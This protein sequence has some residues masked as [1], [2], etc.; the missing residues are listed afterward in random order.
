MFEDFSFE[1]PYLLLLFLLFLLLNRYA[2]ADNNAYYIPHFYE[3]LPHV[4]S[5]HYIQIVLKWL[6]VSSA[7]LAFASPVVVTGMKK[8]ES[9]SIDIVLSLDAS[10][11]MSLTGFNVLDDDQSRWDVVKEVVKDF[12]VKR[13]KDRIGLVLFGSTA[14]VASPLSY[15]KEAQLDIVE[16]IELGVV[17]KSTALID[18][19][20]SAISL[21]K[22]SQKSSK[23][24]VLLSDGEDSASKVPLSVAMKFAKK[25]DIKIY[26]VA[27]D[28]GRSNIL[29][30]ISKES[31]GQ[32]FHANNKEDLYEI[33]RTIDTLE[34][35]AIPDKNIKIVKY[36]AF[37]IL[38]LTL[39]A[40][41]LLL[42]IM[43]RRGGF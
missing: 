20:T 39:I 18:G 33:Y 37:H 14:A 11:S 30:L 26:T 10:G 17:G 42:T 5:K 19:L 22:K 13:E 40:S 12:I 31:G 6:I 16:D 36:Y 43:K 27:I 2:K 1:Y 24:V 3:N 15:A 41:L 38:L 4:K 25:Y 9:Q 7:L 28:K 35:S 29:K 8:Q 23:V 34:R 32:S 21:L